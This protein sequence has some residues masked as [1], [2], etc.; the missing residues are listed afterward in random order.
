MNGRVRA[1]AVGQRLKSLLEVLGDDIEGA[2][3]F[4]ASLGSIIMSI[5]SGTQRNDDEAC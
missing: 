5:I 2:S 1:D 4:H 3:W